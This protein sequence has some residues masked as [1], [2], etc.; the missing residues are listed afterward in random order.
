VFGNFFSPVSPRSSS[1]PDQLL[2][3]FSVLVRVQERKITST[4]IVWRE[5]GWLI[6]KIQTKLHQNGP[7]HKTVTGSSRYSN[8]FCPGF[9]VT[10]LLRINS[11]LEGGRGRQKKLRPSTKDTGSSTKGISG[12]G[13]VTFFGDDRGSADTKTTHWT[14]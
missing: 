1:A 13:N 7:F 4:L 14:V 10:S 12:T 9:F 8:S 2:S 5:Q 3:P 11:E 6:S